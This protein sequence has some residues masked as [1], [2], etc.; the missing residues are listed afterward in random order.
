MA[1]QPS[2]NPIAPLLESLGTDH[3]DPGYAEA[4]ART[5]AA[6]DGPGRPG[7]SRRT[8]V[9]LV[10]G[11]LVAGLILG[12]AAWR[13]DSNAPRAENTRAAL[14]DDIQA[15]QERQSQLALSATQL[16]EQLRASQSAAGAAGPVAEVT[17][18]E[19][20]GQLTPV[21]GPGLR[22]TLDQPSAGQGPAQGQDRS[23]ILDRDLQLLVNDLWAS[24]AE[25]VAI[26]GVR[27]NTRSAIRQAG[28]AILVDNRPV[29]WPLSVEAI[30]DPSA[31]QVKFISTPSYGRFSSF[32]QLYGI[33]FD[34]SAVESLSL[35]GGTAPDLLHAQP[36]T[37]A[38]SPEPTG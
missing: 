16:A 27:L 6:P 15:A 2:R 5:R 10:V 19:N 4:A 30:G 9:L 7:R 8:L 29:F 17:A 1:E 22:I 38:A 21:T 36:A 14:L 26:G 3:L 23:V 12:I 24:G 33:E 28:G 18:L 31:M 32:A 20:Q 11:C 34:R 35:P 13:T 37:T 25:A